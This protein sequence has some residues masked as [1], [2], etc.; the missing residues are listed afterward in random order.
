MATNVCDSVQILYKGDGTQ[1]LYTFPFTYLV[2]QDIYV[3]LWNNQ[4]KEYDEL[5]RDKWSLANATT[6][7]FVDAPPPPDPK[8]KPTDA[9]IFN[10][11]IS[12]STS[13]NTMVARFY[14][15]SAIRAEDL[16]D[17]FDQ[18]KLAIQENRCQLYGEIT[19]LVSDI[20]WNKFSL[21]NRAK[22]GDTIFEQDQKE[23]RWTR[24]LN[25]RYIATSDAIGARLDPYVQDTIPAP[26]PLPGAEQDGKTWF[27]TQDL[28]QRF[29][30]AQAKAWVT[31]ANTGP[32]GP[33][34][35][36]GTPYQTIVSFAAPATRNDGTPLKNGDAWFST[37]VASL[38]IYYNDGDSKQWVNTAKVG[39]RG[40]AGA[41]G[42]YATILSAAP[43]STRL[44]GTPIKNGDAWFN[45]STATLFINYEDGDSKQWVSTAKAGPPG[46]VGPTGPEG[47][48]GPIAPGNGV[49]INAAKQIII[50]DDGTF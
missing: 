28:V 19:H 37:K 43:P 42:S 24:G 45:T 26:V 34:G 40:L 47:P 22:I 13:L 3:S 16:N 20:A 7:E 48:P 14:P 31:L 10:I 21:N 49:G 44:D 4:T 12:R 2:P 39:P 15:G 35:P 25:D 36:A 50:I 41:D 17:D 1:K 18:L 6:I 11:K 29:W 46:P 9:D 33:T 38:F 23:G 32:Q 27:D 30:D 8:V 5:A